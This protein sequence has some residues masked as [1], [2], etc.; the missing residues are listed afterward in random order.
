MLSKDKNFV[1]QGGV[2]N[3]LGKTKEVKAPKFWKSSKDSPST[4]LVYITEAEKGLLLE[5]NLHNSLDNGKPNVGASGLLSLDGQGDMGGSE[6]K[7]T[8]DDGSN[9]PGNTRSNFD[10]ESEAY[11]VAE[12][13]NF[14]YESDAYN[15]KE[16]NNFDYETD[17]YSNIKTTVTPQFNQD[18]KFTGVKTDGVGIVKGETYTAKTIQGVMLDSTISDKEKIATL[19]SLQAIANSTRN[20]G[21]PNVDIEGKAYIQ[22]AIE[23]SLDSLKNDSFY[24]DLTSKMNLDAS[25]YNDGFLDAPVETF[26]KSSIGIT[27]VNPITGAMSII[28]KSLMD[29]FKNKQALDILGFDG[30]K[31]K[32]NYSQVGDDGGILTNKEYLLGNTL[33]RSQI[34]QAVPDIISGGNS[35]PD[36]MVNSYFDNVTGG[37]FSQSYND[38]KSRLENQIST[39]QNG[40]VHKDNI[41]YDYL[42]KEG[43]LNG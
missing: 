26:L 39:S 16:T 23:V 27:G 19:N 30:T 21:K 28:G 25:T 34:N 15:V 29:A 3:Y 1:M 9:N 14:D 18:G 11:N 40:K 4:E 2:K 8:N 7:G 20:S 42:Q 12:T 10:Y 5:A 36:S 6:D 13:K 32:A 41:F 43:L 37:S 24:D 17:A 33:D 35:L 22:N 31:L 38:I